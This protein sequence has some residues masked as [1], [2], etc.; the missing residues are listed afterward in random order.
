MMIFQYTSD[1]NGQKKS[2]LSPIPISQYFKIQ[3]GPK[4]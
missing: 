3:G 1:S 4:K 2:I